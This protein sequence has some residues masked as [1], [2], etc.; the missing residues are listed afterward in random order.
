MIRYAAVLRSN[1]V[2]ECLLIYWNVNNKDWQYPKLEKLAFESRLILKDNTLYTHKSQIRVPI[3]QFEEK[4][5]LENGT[6][7]ISPFKSFYTLESKVWKIVSRTKTAE[8]FLLINP[9]T[10]NLQMLNYKYNYNAE[11]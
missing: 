1:F 10:T 2:D 7:I 9:V 8:Q 4:D 5:N 3:L 11:V 6:F